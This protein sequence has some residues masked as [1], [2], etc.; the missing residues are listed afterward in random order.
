MVPGQHLLLLCEVHILQHPLELVHDILVAHL[1]DVPALLM[2]KMSF[3]MI[4]RM[5]IRLS[6]IMMMNW[7]RM[8]R[9]N[10]C[11][12]QILWKGNIKLTI[13]KNMSTF[14]NMYKFGICFVI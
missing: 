4:L 7:R 6:R 3:G 9:W 2:V 13:K 11:M 14:G 5:M 1:V 12:L 10:I 8:S